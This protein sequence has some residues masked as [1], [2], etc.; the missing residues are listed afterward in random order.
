MMPNFLTYSGIFL[1]LWLFPRGLFFFLLA[2]L[3]PFI[4]KD[5]IISKSF[6]FIFSKK[7][8]IS[9]LK[10]AA[11]STGLYFFIRWLGGYGLLGVIIIVLGV[12]GYKL[13][14]GRAYFMEKIREIEII[15]WGK[16]ND[17]RK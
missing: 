3:I 13:W 17:K 8:F 4:I 10:T 6:I 5:I 12:S 7:Y 15:I 14:S 11:I 16:T 2:I 1:L 9:L